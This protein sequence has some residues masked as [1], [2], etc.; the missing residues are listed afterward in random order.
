[1]ASFI[2]F[3]SHQAEC[4]GC[5]RPVPSGLAGFTDEIQP[6]RLTPVCATCL[7]SLDAR[8]CGVLVIVRESGRRIPC[9]LAGGL[10]ARQVESSGPVRRR[11][12][13]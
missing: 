4:S 5:A 6:P 12:S 13:P 11:E 3:I 9:D 1:M 2:A 8:L 7:H 10:A